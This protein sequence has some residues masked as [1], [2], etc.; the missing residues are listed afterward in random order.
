MISR[1]RLAEIAALF[2]D[3]TRAGIVTSLWDGRARPAIGQ[4]HRRAAHLD[5]GVAELAGARAEEV[6]AVAVGVKRDHVRAEQARQDLL[7]P[8]QP[9]EDVR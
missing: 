8:G 9:G 6:A 2:G 7:S 3:P 1:Y 4:D 5:A